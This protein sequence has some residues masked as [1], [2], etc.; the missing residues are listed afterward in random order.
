[1]MSWLLIGACGIADAGDYYKWTDAHGTV[2]YSQTP[3]R[4]SAAQTVRVDET[5]PV[6]PLAAPSEKKGAVVESA[7]AKANAR[8]VAA[9][10]ATA[11]HN[12][13][14]LESGKMVASAENN[15]DVRAIAPAQRRQALTDA[16]AQ[17]A[18]YC[19]RP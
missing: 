15:P 13:A 5:T 3:P 6:V 17:V 19:S 10:C 4:E 8:A 2:H 1:M 18:T 16:R 7:L 12:V 9:N 14:V 11:R